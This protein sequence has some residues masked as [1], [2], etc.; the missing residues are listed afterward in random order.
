MPALTIVPTT[1]EYTDDLADRAVSPDDVHDAV[2]TR[3][4][5]AQLRRAM[6][7]LP[8][9]DRHLLVMRFGVAGLRHPMS[10]REMGARLNCSHTEVRRMEQRALQR[11]RDIYDEELA[12]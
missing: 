9:F 8:D 7:C 5:V 11:L 2:V 6:R 12:A 3:I 4:E 10:I 1:V